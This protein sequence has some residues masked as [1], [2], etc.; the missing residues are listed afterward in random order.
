MDERSGGAWKRGVVSMSTTENRAGRSLGRSATDRRSATKRRPVADRRRA[1]DGFSLIE[2]LLGLSLALC[3]A[4]AVAPLWTGLQALAS[5]EGDA[6]VWSLQGR[7][8]GARLERDLRMSGFQACPFAAASVVLQATSS[9]VVLLQQAP[10]ASAPMLVEWE[11]TG[12]S[13]MR[14]WGPCPAN[15]PT[16]FPHSLYTDNK[17]MLEDVA[18]AGSQFSYTLAGSETPAPVTAGDLPLVDSVAVHVVGVADR[19]E[20]GL[21]WTACERVGR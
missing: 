21:E 8:A 6:T 9:Q 4:L 18:V 13:L 2:L 7:V 12:G 14:R 3:V 17:T 19:A 20:S 5:R 15:L 11:L 1:E 10:G 16:A